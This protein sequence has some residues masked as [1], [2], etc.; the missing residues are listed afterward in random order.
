MSED[1]DASKFNNGVLNTIFDGD[2]YNLQN[3]FEFTVDAKDGTVLEFTY[4]CLGYNGKVAGKKFY[5]EVFE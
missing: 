3:P 1:R 5:I 4:E 2:L